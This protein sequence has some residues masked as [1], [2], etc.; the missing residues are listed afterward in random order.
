MKILVLSDSHNDVKTMRLLVE[1]IEPDCIF[2]LGD[3][4]TDALELKQS[5]PNTPLHCVRGNCDDPFYDRFEQ[6]IS[7]NGK[8]FYITHGDRF[9]VKTGLT[10]LLKRA[11]GFGANAVLFGHTHRPLLKNENGLWVMNP[12]CVS[13]QISAHAAASYG[14]VEISGSEIACKLHTVDSAL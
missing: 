6:L 8:L 1:K 4:I 7:L 9:G 11:E 14:I 10:S 3:L 12:G 5:F 2:H 13:R